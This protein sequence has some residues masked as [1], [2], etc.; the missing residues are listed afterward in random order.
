MR[1]EYGAFDMG[2]IL[3]G[4][5]KLAATSGIVGRCREAVVDVLC[6]WNSGPS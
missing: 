3:D 5:R 2:K 6:Q 4:G 1:R